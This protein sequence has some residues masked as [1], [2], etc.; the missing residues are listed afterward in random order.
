MKVAAAVVTANRAKCEVGGEYDLAWATVHRTQ[1]SPWQPHVTLHQWLRPRVLE[2]AYTSW[3]LQPWALDLGDAGAPYRWDPDRRAILQ[4]EIDAA[5]LHTY[6]LNRDQTLHIL[7]TFRALRDAEARTYGEYRTERLVL[8]EY[9]RMA[10]AILADGTGWASS[11][12][13]PAGLGPRHHAS[14]GV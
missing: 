5:M 10:A 11:L 4:A 1:P 2:L 8:A 6:S 14:V 9:D 13:V 7:G 3:T 12:E